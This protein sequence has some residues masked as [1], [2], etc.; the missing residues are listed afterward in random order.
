MTPP[1]N[2]CWHL[3][4]HPAFFRQAD[5]ANTSSQLNRLP[6]LDESNIIV[7]SLVIIAGMYLDLLHTADYLVLLPSQPNVSLKN[8]STPGHTVGSCQ[9]II[10]LNQSSSTVVLAP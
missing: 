5:G 4:P 8:R 2:H 6:Q 3:S 1:S 10:W 7:I 9:D